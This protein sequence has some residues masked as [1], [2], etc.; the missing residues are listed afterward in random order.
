MGA[1]LSLATLPAIRLTDARIKTLLQIVKSN[2]IAKNDEDAVAFRD[3]AYEC[4]KNL[5]IFAKGREVEVLG[6]DSCD[7]LLWITGGM[8]WGDPPTDAFEP[9]LALAEQDGVC[10]KM[11]E[12]SKA[13]FKK[14]GR[15][16]MENIVC[17]G[18]A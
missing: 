3:D 11:L 7:H 5:H 13:D 14:L 15:E 8:S 12:W 6:M 4:I 17:N 1:D 9:M 18:G 10:E 16:K 2:K